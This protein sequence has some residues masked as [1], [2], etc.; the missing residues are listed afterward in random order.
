MYPVLLLPQQVYFRSPCQ[1]VRG[2]YL[3][4]PPPPPPPRHTYD[5]W[6]HCPAN[7]TCEGQWSPVQAALASIASMYFQYCAHACAAGAA[8]SYCCWP[9]WPVRA[10]AV[11][12]PSRPS[13][14][15]S[16]PLRHA[17]NSTQAA[18]RLCV[19]ETPSMSLIAGKLSPYA[20]CSGA[21]SVAWAHHCRCSAALI[22]RS[23]SP[24]NSTEQQHQS[25][26]GVDH[27]LTLGH[28]GMTLSHAAHH[29]APVIS[30]HGHSLSSQM[31]YAY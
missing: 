17:I 29:A 1:G 12:R 13:S 30:M 28:Y 31:S 27:C 16:R 19:S 5:V 20:L 8:V 24:S 3:T 22:G 23:C 21:P 10:A 11:Q 15:H 25:T 4:P 6:H 9:R 26:W 18:N 2:T 14:S 7:K